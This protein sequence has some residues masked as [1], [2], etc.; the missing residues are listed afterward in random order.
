MTA[1]VIFLF[2]NSCLNLAQLNFSCHWHEDCFL[3]HFYLFSSV[4]RHELHDD[5]FC[6]ILPVWQLAIV[7]VASAGRV[8][9]VVSIARHI[10]SLFLLSP[11]EML[12]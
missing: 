2:F 7:S 3:D 4:L 9:R 12:D 5:S 6:S 1:C 11:E 10:F 8:L